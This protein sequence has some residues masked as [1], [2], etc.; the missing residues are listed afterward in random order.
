MS[1]LTALFPSA[2]IILVPLSVVPKVTLD[3]EP[4]IYLNST[5]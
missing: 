5:V 1:G 4:E 2:F 3:P